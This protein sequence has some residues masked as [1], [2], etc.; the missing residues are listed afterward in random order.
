M[1]KKKFVIKVLI[2]GKEKFVHFESCWGYKIGDF[3]ESIK[4]STPEEARDVLLTL[5]NDERK[6][7]NGDIYPSVF[8]Q[9]ACFL[10]NK[11][12]SGN[13]KCFISE[14]IIQDVPE[15]AFEF[16]TEI[17]KPKGFIY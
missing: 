5:I 2:D 13:V 12:T 3:Q 11:K 9:H 10:N 17:K 16:S 7:S 6:M 4:F 14:I 8:L 15:F 1:T